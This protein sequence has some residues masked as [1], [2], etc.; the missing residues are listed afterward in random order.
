M[1]DR[2]HPAS[3]RLDGA[4]VRSR[5]GVEESGGWWWWMEDPRQQSRWRSGRVGEEKVAT[6]AG[7]DGGGARVPQTRSGSLIDHS[8][9]AMGA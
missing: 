7:G 3:V 9:D 6:R 8:F 4:R 2:V 5:K 1:L